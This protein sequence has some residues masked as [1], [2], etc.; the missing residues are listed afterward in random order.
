[1]IVDS[2]SVDIIGIYLPESFG[3]N[4]LDR[5]FTSRRIYAQLQVVTSSEEVLSNHLLVFLPL[6]PVFQLL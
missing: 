1:M 5:L 6:L 3:I 2:R 4:R